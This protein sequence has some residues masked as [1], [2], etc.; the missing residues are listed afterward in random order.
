MEVSRQHITMFLICRPEPGNEA[1]KSVWQS[2]GPSQWCPVSC[3]YFS[4]RSVAIMINVLT[5]ALAWSVVIVAL[6]NVRNWFPFKIKVPSLIL[7][8]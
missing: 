5:I 4:S 1:S 2:K 8:R 3:R 7:R 6:L